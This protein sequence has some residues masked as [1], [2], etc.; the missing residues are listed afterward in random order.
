MTIKPWEVYS[1]LENN[2][3]NTLEMIPDDLKAE[4][5]KKIIRPS[6]LDE[7]ART[8][9]LAVQFKDEVSLQKIQNWMIE[10]FNKGNFGHK[11]SRKDLDPTKV[12][13][14]LLKGIYDYR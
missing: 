2:Y 5:Q 1:I 9:S 8:I 7:Y 11:L 6:D 10:R 12:Y 14:S 3:K 13:E 4:F